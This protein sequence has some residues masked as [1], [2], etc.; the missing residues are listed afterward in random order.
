MAYNAQATIR[1][2][3]NLNVELLET[4]SKRNCYPGMIYFEPH[5]NLKVVSPFKKSTESFKVNLHF[6]DLTEDS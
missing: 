3:G 6:L 2:K 1:F 4:K 5:L